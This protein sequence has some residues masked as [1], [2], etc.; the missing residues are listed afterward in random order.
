[1][2]VEEEM[3]VQVEVHV[4]VEVE[5]EAINA[6]EGE[7]TNEVVGAKEVS[8]VEEA[9]D[10]KVKRVRRKRSKTVGMDAVAKEPPTFS[11]TSPDSAYAKGWTIPQ[12]KAVCREHKLRVGGKKSELQDRLHRYG[13]I[14]QVVDRVQAVMKA[15]LVQ[16]WFA[17]RGAGLYN[18]EKVCNDSDVVSMDDIADIPIERLYSFSEQPAGEGNGPHVWYIFD[19]RTF[20]MLLANCRGGLSRAD[21]MRNPYT[22]AYLSDSDCHR[23]RKLMTIGKAIGRPI[24]TNYTSQTGTSVDGEND[25]ATPD[26]PINTGSTGQAA[27]AQINS[28]MDSSNE[29]GEMSIYDR[30]TDVF[31]TIDS[32]GH[33][34][35]PSWMTSLDRAGKI[36]FIEHVI[37]IFLYRA[38]LSTTM[39]SRIMPSRTS[40]L[41]ASALAAVRHAQGVNSVLSNNTLNLMLCNICEEFV[42]SGVDDDARALGCYY[43][44]MATT[45]VSPDARAA[46][47]W[48][49]EATLSANGH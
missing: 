6:C 2:T 5:L 19:T 27:P 41:L 9:N 23:F 20:G 37:D 26:V 14:S 35:N 11:L 36:T 38:Q 42:M 31:N 30:I 39:R 24:E 22:R 4:E 7:T 18:G 1:M 17:L 34:S 21:Q 3:P 44:L 49:Y 47:P 13:S 43:V 40:D 25:V 28:F 10:V 45:I 12:L 15:K 8:R 33:Y 48:L 32:F 29:R 46:M 16:Q